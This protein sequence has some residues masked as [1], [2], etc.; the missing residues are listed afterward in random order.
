MALPEL[1]TWGTSVVSLICLKLFSVVSVA[2]RPLG[3]VDRAAARYRVVPE[4]KASERETRLY[5][6][7]VHCRS[8]F[9]WDFLLAGVPVFNRRAPRALMGEDISTFVRA[10]KQ[11]LAAHVRCRARRARPTHAGAS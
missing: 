9:L 8:Q 3:P 5:A 1:L 11:R 2:L 10:C 4:A 7:H 6:L